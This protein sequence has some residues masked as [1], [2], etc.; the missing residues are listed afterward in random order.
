MQLLRKINWD[1]LSVIGLLLV[2]LFLRL[3]FASTVPLSIDEKIKISLVRQI[4]LDPFNSHLPVGDRSI[5]HSLFSVYLL[6][7]GFLLFGPGILAGRFF[8]VL[9]GTLSLY[10]IYRVTKQQLGNQVGL[11]TLLLLTFDQF[12]IGE[13]GQIREEAPLFLFTS[14]AIYSFFQAITADKKWISITG[15]CLGL[16]FLC[17]EIIL[18]VLLTLI[19]FLIIKR[20]YRSRF[21]SK[22]ILVSAAIML[23][24]IF[25][26][27]W[28]GIDNHFVHYSP[29][30]FTFGFSLRVIYLYFGEIMA[31]SGQ[32]SIIESDKYHQVIYLK[33]LGNSL[34]PLGVTS[35]EF[36]FV[37]WITGIFIWTGAAYSLLKKNW[38]NDLIAFCML[39]FF[40]ISLIVSLFDPALFDSHWR[41]S[42]TIFPGMILFSQML[43]NIYTSSAY[44]KLLSLAGCVYLILHSLRFVSTAHPPYFSLIQ[45]LQ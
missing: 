45:T 26:Y 19:I 15:L 31:L 7:L 37:H 6:K 1:T 27:L 22:Y 36:P 4:S 24:C 28:W 38:E 39:L 9:L 41:A 25:P 42:L 13:S 10:F 44:G 32:F 33:C 23:S 30:F 21:N 17:K 43:N 35:N 20:N 5:P 18:S 12:H 40:L 11:L 14:M 34:I 8:F 2:A 16:G 29:D 3:G